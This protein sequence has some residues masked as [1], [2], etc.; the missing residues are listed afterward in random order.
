MVFIQ[1]VSYHIYLE[2]NTVVALL[3][4][5]GLVLERPAHSE[6]PLD[7]DGDGEEHAGGVGDVTQHLTPGH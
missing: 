7:G 5:P 1:L 2:Q 4:H 3:S 6:E